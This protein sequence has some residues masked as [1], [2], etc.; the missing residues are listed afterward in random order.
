MTVRRTRWSPDTCDC[1]LEYEWDDSEPEDQRTH[2]FAVAD[3]VCTHHQVHDNRS[4]LFDA[5]AEEN[6][7]KNKAVNA[8]VGAAPRLVDHPPSFA[9][10]GNR[11]VEVWF[12]GK[13]LTGPERAQA[14]AALAREVGPKARLR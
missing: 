1:V 5:V 12:E 7:R 2:A 10:D 11:N 14:V 4:Q 3:A 13:P 6:T 9:F 8:L